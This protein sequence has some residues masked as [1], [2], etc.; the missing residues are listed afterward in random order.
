MSAKFK[1]SRF[2][3]GVEVQ[4]LPLSYRNNAPLL[5]CQTHLALHPSRG[6]SRHL[7]SDSGFSSA[8]R[9]PEFQGRGIQG[10]EIQGSGFRVQGSGFRVQG[11]GFWV[12]GSGFRALGIYPDNLSSPSPRDSGKSACRCRVSSKVSCLIISVGS[13]YLLRCDCL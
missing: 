1:R 9:S 10:R 6:G 4:A 7:V 12:R 3:V 8:S 13:P 11:S 5:L 2:G